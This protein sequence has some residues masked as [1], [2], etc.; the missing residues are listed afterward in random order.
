MRFLG[1]LFLLV[2]IVAVVGIFR[3]WF[4]VT[5]THAGENKDVTVGVHTDR[6][7]EDASKLAEVPERVA[8][9]V[10]AIG[11]KVA[12]DESEIDGTVVSSDTPS[13]RLVVSAGAETLELNVP[14]TVP[15]ERNGESLAFDRL[16][17]STRVR[18]RFRHDGDA[19]KL[20]RVDVLDR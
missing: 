15:I 13:R 11:K 10:R 5:T 7:R 12:V 14:S 6:M 4:S 9:Q 8:K 3:G 18:L 17:P 19:R 20:A 2:L 1:F 16:R